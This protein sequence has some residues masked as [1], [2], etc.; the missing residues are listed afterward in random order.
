MRTLNDKLK[1]KHENLEA[2]KKNSDYWLHSPLRQVE[3]T[4][5]FFEEKLRNMLFDGISIVDM[6]CGSGWLLDL[7]ID[8]GV[9]F[10]YLGLD[11]N[12]V[13]ID[14]LRDKYS[15]IKAARFELVDLEVDLDARFNGQADMVVNCFNFFETANLEVSFRNGARLMSPKSKLIVFTIDVTYLMLAVSKTFEGF[16][17]LLLEYDEMKSGGEVPFFFQNIDLGESESSELKYASVLYS[18][19]DFYKQAEQNGL[20]LSDYGEVIKTGKFLPKIYQYLSF[21]QQ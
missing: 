7:I 2:W 19:G 20:R 17:S 4:K 1:F 13:F 14:Y 21:E 18:V 16:K 12:P 10:K 11:F 3:D 9:E 15:S 6:G 5:D 8:I